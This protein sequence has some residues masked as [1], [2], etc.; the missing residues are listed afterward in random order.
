MVDVITFQ[1]ATK[2][3]C[4]VPNKRTNL[5]NGFDAL[6]LVRPSAQICDFIGLNVI[7]CIRIRT[8][9]FKHLT[10]GTADE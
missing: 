7:V 8:F 2:Y 9:N 3:H 4:Q 6:E 1:Q 10:L 5:Y